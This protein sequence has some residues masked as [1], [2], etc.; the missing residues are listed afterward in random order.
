M[1][2]VIAALRWWSAARQ[3]QSEHGNRLADTARDTAAQFESVSGRFWCRRCLRGRSN[4]MPETP[5]HADCEVAP[6]L[7][8]N[9]ERPIRVPS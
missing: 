7:P 9:R 6:V 5:S 3:R 4:V 8:V 2:G 1:N